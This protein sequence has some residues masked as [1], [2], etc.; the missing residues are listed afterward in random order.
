VPLSN[1]ALVACYCA[2]VARNLDATAIREAYGMSQILNNNPFGVHRKSDWA[3]QIALWWV[4]H[5]T[6]N[7]RVAPHSINAPKFMSPTADKGAGSF[8]SVGISLVWN[9]LKGWRLL[10][11]FLWISWIQTTLWNTRKQEGATL[12]VWRMT[13]HSAGASMYYWSYIAMSSCSNSILGSNIGIFMWFRSTVLW[14]F[15]CGCLCV[16]KGTQ[17]T[18]T[19]KWLWIGLHG[20]CRQSLL[21]IYSG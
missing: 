10:Y 15:L 17:H 3:K 16:G 20:A 8:G 6:S 7:A 12:G 19:F 2:R 13:E 5:G 11:L 18:A 9:V 1:F 4:T 14:K 21:N